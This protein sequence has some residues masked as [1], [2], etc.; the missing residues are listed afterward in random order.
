MKTI[1]FLILL[2]LA[3]N[4]SAQNDEVPPII[5]DGYVY[6]SIAYFSTYELFFRTTNI[7]KGYC[8]TFASIASV[9]TNY[10]IGSNRG[11]S[12]ENKRHMIYGSVL[13]VFTTTIVIGFNNKRDR[14]IIKLRDDI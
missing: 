8:L 5:F 13:A 3:T 7:S 2:F 14:Q 4:I 12:I 9:L 10:A 6:G 11:Y 1:T